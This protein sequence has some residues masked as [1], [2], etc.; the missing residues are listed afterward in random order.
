MWFIWELGN[1]PHKKQNNQL[2][3]T[4]NFLIKIHFSGKEILYI[5]MRSGTVD[6][7]VASFVCGASRAQLQ[8]I[9][10]DHLLIIIYQFWLFHPTVHDP[11][12]LR[13]GTEPPMKCAI[14]SSLL[15]ATV[16]LGRLVRIPRKS[17]WMSIPLQNGF[18]T[19]L[20]CYKPVNATIGLW[21]P[22]TYSRMGRNAMQVPP[23]LAKPV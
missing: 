12:P 16:L 1:S 5:Y 19:S 18:L 14:H 6:M 7:Y 13:R 23:K 3:Q 11:W 4:I 2:Y 9:S 20:R 17:W 10:Y 15:Y 8:R 22:L 21:E